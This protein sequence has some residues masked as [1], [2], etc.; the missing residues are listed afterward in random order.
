MFG[1]LGSVI[2][3]RLGELPT[4]KTLKGFLFGRSVCRKCHH[5]LHA[6]DL[7]PLRSFFS[8]KG[9]C[10]YCKT[11]LSRRY[12]LLEIGTVVIFVGV[13]LVI[14]I[15]HTAYGLTEISEM[16][17]SPQVWYLMIGLRLLF[18]ITLYD[19]KEYELHLTASVLLLLLSF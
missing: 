19:F 10:R 15:Q 1:S 4:W 17:G 18:L 12:P 2:F 13:R 16:L 3:F 9:R 7:I 14:G 8:Q 5:T 11:K 6:K